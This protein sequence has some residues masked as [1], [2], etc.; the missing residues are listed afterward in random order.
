[1]KL[2]EGV[3]IVD[4][5]RYFPGPFATLRL[6]DWGAEVVKVEAPEGEPG[7]CIN[8]YEDAEGSVFRSV[9]RGKRGI[10][11]NLKDEVDR[12]VVL[13]EIASADALIEGFRPGVAARLGLGYDAVLAVK[14]DI[15]YCSLTGYGQSGPYANLSGHDLNYMALSGCLDQLLDGDGRPIKPAIAFADLIGGIAASEALLA[16]IV[17]RDK[18]GEP[19]YIDVSLTEA[20]LSIM[21][22]H[23]THWSLGQG[24]H[25]QMDG[26][27]SYAIYETSDGRHVTLAAMEDKFWKNFCDG[28][29]APDLYEGKNT[30]PG[31]DNPYYVRICAIFREHDFDHW[32]RFFK[33]N[34]CCFAPVLNIGEA[35]E[36]ES[37]RERG[38]VE[39]N[40]GATYIAT[41]YFD[42]D[43][44]LTGDEPYPPLP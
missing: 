40:W 7:R 43:G 15:V 36:V 37:F 8:R 34:D 17:R 25:G 28:V 2:L 30:I 38:L 19:C 33:E 23:A 22:L 18:T 44:F 39:Q 29:G 35:L 14:P 16:G 13:D 5:T 31:A 3:K 26:T 32:M 12:R 11:A 4:L 24:L 41:H 1:M 27:I 21:G 10:F 9:N 6:S 42:G 20:V